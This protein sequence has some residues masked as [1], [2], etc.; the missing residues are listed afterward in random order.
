MPYTII[1][2]PDVD[3]DLDKLSDP[4][5]SRIKTAISRLANAPRPSGAI[6]LTDL[7]GAYRIRVGKYRVVYRIQDQ[8][9]LILVIAVAERGKIYPLSKRRIKK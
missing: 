8:K 4:E 7:G 2:L 9:L 5:Y 6:K 3:N 1:S